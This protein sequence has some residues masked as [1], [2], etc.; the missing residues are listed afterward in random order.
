MTTVEKATTATLDYPALLAALWP[1]PSP[2]EYLRMAGAGGTEWYRFLRGGWKQ[3]GQFRQG[4]EPGPERLVTLA[5][6]WDVFLSPALTDHPTWGT[7]LRPLTVLWAGRRLK[8][9]AR[10]RG[11]PGSPLVAGEADAARECFAACSVPPSVVLH[12]GLRVTG[13]WLLRASVGLAAGRTLLWRLAQQ[14]EG[15]RE[16]AEDPAK[17]ELA[18]PGTACERVFPRHTV[19][20]EATRPLRRVA[21]EDIERWLSGGQL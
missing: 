11:D 20:A 2:H 13:L 10:R 12:E 19:T 17:V 16:L 3:L 5:G 9:A 15:E 7:S 18:V 6:G 21:V 1:A 4:A 14:V 8:L